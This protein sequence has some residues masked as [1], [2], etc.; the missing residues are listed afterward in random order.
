MTQTHTQAGSAGRPAP[1]ASPR[2]SLVVRFAGDSGD[3]MQLAGTQFTDTSAIAGNDIATLPDFPA[4]IRAPAGTVAGVSGFQI[5]F[6]SEDIY[7]PG[8]RVDALIAMNPA[9]FKAHLRDVEP[10]GIVIV[11]DDEFSKS[12][13]KK[14]GYPVPQGSKD[15][16]N[17]LDDPQLAQRYK[18]HRVPIT[19]LNQEVLKDAGLDPKSISRCR[20]MW[21]LG[22]VYWLFD[23]P[24]DTTIDHIN[25][26]F[27]KRKNLPVVA[28]ANVRALQSGFNYGE[29]AEIFTER[30]AVN[31]ADIKPGTYRK[32]TGNEALAMGLIA[33][34]NLSGKT[35]V[36]CSYPITPASDILH[37]LAPMKHYGV[38]TFQAED[39]IAA[40]CAAIG[41]SFAG[42]LGVTGTSGPGLALKSEA[43]GLAVMTELPL[44]VID[45]Q[46]GGPSTGLPTKTEQSDLLQ[47][48][49]GRNGDCPVVVLAPQSPAD[50]FQIAIDAARI[51]MQHMVPV[52]L[53][54]DGYLANGSEPWL[55]PDPR[56][57][58]QI[59]ITHPHADAEQASGGQASSSDFKPYQRDDKLARPWAIPGAPGLEHRIGGLEK[60][61]ITGNVNYEPENH[62]RMTDLR[63]EKI[64]KLA[65]YLP[66]LKVSQGNDSGDLLVLGWGGTHG[67]ITTAVQ[68]ARKK[69]FSVSQAHLRHLSPMPKNTGDLL[70]RFK[71]VL[72]PELNTGQLS[73]LIRGKCLVDA[74]SLN[75][76]QGKP[77]LV[78]EIEAKIAEM[79]A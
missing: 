33:A 2:T 55:I 48:M 36:Y 65:D 43:I 39:E 42:Q 21:A 79:L 77:F 46:R 63:K 23:R 51:A 58:E 28:D 14:A 53:L 29:T 69:G 59:I 18:L 41:A 74:Q 72:I 40:C 47:A 67:S 57:F 75:K 50:C 64:E 37:N 56:K 4:E 76:V 31:K 60:Q 44:V 62:Q 1:V 27:R 68:R 24:L 34:S 19:K 11:N 8:D 73:L 30:F 6:A 35:L 12:N 5:H 22:L 49:Y 78:E 45:V 32:I 52:L 26:T 7:H 10:G 70:R 66:E 61:D 54:T 15:P 3:G 9:A 17:P 71:Q 20:N 38:K 16:V 13:L 25:D